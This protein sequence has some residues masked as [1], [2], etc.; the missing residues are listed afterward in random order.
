[1]GLPVPG[2]LGFGVFNPL[3]PVVPGLDLLTSGRAGLGRAHI[4]IYLK[5]VQRAGC[6]WLGMGWPALGHPDMLSHV[7][8]RCLC[9]DSEKITHTTF[10]FCS[11]VI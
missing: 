8:F 3:G 1:M 4:Y 2:L 9:L 11:H 5:P 6:C 7:H 10:V